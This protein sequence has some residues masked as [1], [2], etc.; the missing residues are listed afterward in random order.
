MVVTYAF[1]PL[2]LRDFN[3]LL[4]TFLKDAIDLLYHIYT[5]EKMG[6]TYG[7]YSG[8]QHSSSLIWE[9]FQKMER[10]MARKITNTKKTKNI[11]L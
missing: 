8:W 1:G 10:N 4:S 11:S 6:K 3:T 2:V 7:L 9:F 5:S